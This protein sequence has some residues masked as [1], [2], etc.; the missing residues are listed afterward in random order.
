MIKIPY[1][2]IVATPAVLFCIGAGLNFLVISAN[3]GA[4][5]VLMPHLFWQKLGEAHATMPT[6]F[7]FDSVHK[8][9]VTSDHLRWLADWVSVPDGTASP[10]DLLVWLGQWLSPY[11][12]GAWLALLWKRG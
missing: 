6:G 7:V 10:G 1:W 4:M 9:M 11:S 5:P 8:A 3:G 2:W 12:I